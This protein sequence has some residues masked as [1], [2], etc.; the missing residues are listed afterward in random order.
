MKEYFFPELGYFTAKEIEQI[1]ETM[2]GFSFM[3][4]KV[5]SSNYAGNH[6]LIIK[7]DYEDT[8]ENIKSFFLRC[9]LS[10]ISK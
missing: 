7:T 3:K 2:D 1:K 10:M 4:F 5:S 6:T 9:C 8:P